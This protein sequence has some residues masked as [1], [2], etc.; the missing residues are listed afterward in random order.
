VRSFPICSE[1]KPWLEP[2]KGRIGG[3]GVELG[4]ISPPWTWAVVEARA[5]GR[6]Q[7]QGLFGT[8]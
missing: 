4:N 2:G 7:A 1:M 5:G 8:L 3:L 6:P